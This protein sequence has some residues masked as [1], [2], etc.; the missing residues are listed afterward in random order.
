MGALDKIIRNA[1]DMYENPSD[2]LQM[3]TDRID[4]FNKGRVAEGNSK[5][6]GY[7]TLTDDERVKQFT[8]GTLDNIGGGG[9]GAL[10]MIR[11]GGL[12]NLNLVHNLTDDLTSTGHRLTSRKSMYS[13]SVAIASDNVFPFMT[14]PTLVFNPKSHL[15]DPAQ[16]KG[17]QLFSRDAYTFRAQN[18]RDV[19]Q[20]TSNH[21]LSNDFRFTEGGGPDELGHFLS[22]ATAPKF[23]SFKEFEKRRDGAGALR[24]LTDLDKE[25]SDMLGSE[26][27]QWLNDQRPWSEEIRSPVSGSARD[28]ENLKYLAQRANEGDDTAKFILQ[29]LRS[30]PS[31]Y[32]ELKVLGEVPLNRRNVS[33][34]MLPEFMRRTPEEEAISEWWSRELGVPVGT[35]SQLL[36]EHLHSTYQ[37]LPEQLNNAVHRN[38]ADVDAGRVGKKFGPSSQNKGVESAYDSMPE[39][40]RR[41]VDRDTWSMGMRE[42]NPDYVEGMIRRQ[43]PYS[44]GFASDVSSILTASD[45]LK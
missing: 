43:L 39:F 15:F 41:Y 29:G 27:R 6:I 25:Y 19:R 32:A 22:V 18:P 3:F 10:G 4:N 24:Q 8:T 12:P 28:P 21:R 30:M 5:D 1:K 33:H 13:P 36:P 42:T 9:M 20:M 34:I 26:Y 40:V 17:N 45:T 37:A 2:Y 14:K 16:A 35:P 23:N 44:R 7:R 38:Y 11:K 31:D